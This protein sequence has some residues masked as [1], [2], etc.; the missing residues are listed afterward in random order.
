MN[1]FNYTIT[2]QSEFFMV[3]ILMASIALFLLIGIAK[4]LK[5]L[6]L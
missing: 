5:R 6:G 2:S 3:A 4:I 1:I